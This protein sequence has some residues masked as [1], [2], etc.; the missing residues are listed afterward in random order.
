MIKTNALKIENIQE[1]KWKPNEK[2]MG[3]N[4]SQCLWQNCENSIERSEIRIQNV[5]VRE[6]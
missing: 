4:R 1:N 3:Q 2:Q 5:K 6:N